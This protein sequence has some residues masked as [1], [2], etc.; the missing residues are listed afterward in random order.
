VTID[1]S[2]VRALVRRELAKH[3]GARPSRTHVHAA[4]LEIYQG[5]G[6]DDSLDASAPTPCII[7]TDRPCNQS[8]YCKKLGY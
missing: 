4:L 1:R 6:C 3:L 5:P 7:E 2:R 8:G